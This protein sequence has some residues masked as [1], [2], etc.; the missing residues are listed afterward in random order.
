MTFYRPVGFGMAGHIVLTTK[1]PW[2]Q[3]AGLFFWRAFRQRHLY[4][5]YFQLTFVENIGSK[6]YNYRRT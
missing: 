2:L 1:T 5:Q 6:G 3:T 4:L